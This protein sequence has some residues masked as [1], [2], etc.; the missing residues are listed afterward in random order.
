MLYYVQYVTIGTLYQIWVRRGYNGGCLLKDDA[1]R[2][3][4]QDYIPVGTK[5]VVTLRP[6]PA[7]K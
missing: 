2:I 6:V 4:P 5:V 7:H 1:R 3:L